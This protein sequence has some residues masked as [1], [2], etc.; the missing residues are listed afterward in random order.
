MAWD[1]RHAAV[2]RSWGLDVAL[3]IGLLLAAVVLVVGDVLVELPM[4][5]DQIRILHVLP[6]LAAVVLPFPLVDRTPGLTLVAARSPA[7]LSLLR[8]G[9]VVLASLPVPA[10]LL[11]GGWTL[12][13][14]LVGVAF[15]GIAAAAC[16]FLGLWYWAPMLGLLVV[17]MQWGSRER[18]AVYTAGWPWLVVDLALLAAGGGAYVAVETAR[19]RRRVRAAGTSS[20][21]RRGADTIR[22]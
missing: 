12:P 20:E 7:A 10:A 5:R 6:A 4:L 11:A 17:W 22:P 9:G 8:L 14:A 1:D 15:V 19:V 13:A 3:A 18:E 16:A 21:T 2:V